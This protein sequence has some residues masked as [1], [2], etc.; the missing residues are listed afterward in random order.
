MN[1][2]HV[3]DL[4]LWEQQTLNRRVLKI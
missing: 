2:K 1:E 4:E 3:P